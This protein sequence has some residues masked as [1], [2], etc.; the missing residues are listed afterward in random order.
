MQ[1]DLALS[2]HR[3]SSLFR[4]LSLYIITESP[5]GLLNL[6]QIC[7]YGNHHTRHVKLSAVVF[8]SDDYLALMGEYCSII[9]HDVIYFFPPSLSLL[10]SL[11]L[12]LPPSS[13]LPSL[14]PSLSPS[15]YTQV[16]F[17]MVLVQSY[18]MLDRQ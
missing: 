18:Y 11:P 3:P 13:F 10:S 9:S 8:G 6:P 5:Q 4:P 15:F 16:V 17:V 7:Y 1:L 2:F 14:C 12:S